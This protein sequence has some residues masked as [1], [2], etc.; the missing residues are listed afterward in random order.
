MEF[1]DFKVM[2]LVERIFCC[3]DCTRR[4]GE[5][6][7]RLEI[8]PPTRPP[9]PE[10]RKKRP[11]NVS[12]ITNM[13]PPSV[14]VTRATSDSN[15]ASTEDP[16]E[17]FLPISVLPSSPF[18]FAIENP[19]FRENSV[20]TTVLYNSSDERGWQSIELGTP[21]E[22]SP[23]EKPPNTFSLFAD[24]HLEQRPQLLPRRRTFCNL[25]EV[26]TG[27]LEGRE[28]VKGRKDKSSIAQERPIW[29]SRSTPAIV[30][31]PIGWV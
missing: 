23:A 16:V 8:E 22:E 17:S 29:S 30:H 9:F 5:R 3:R 13:V 27:V 26:S 11:P 24:S 19:L 18:D 31:T 28:R 12:T 4:K 20:S 10:S 14:V 6:K 15:L 7:F 21:N 2:Y 25:D 1:A